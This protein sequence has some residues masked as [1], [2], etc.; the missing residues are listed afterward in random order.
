V[1]DAL[2]ALLPIA[3]AAAVFCGLIWSNAE[4][5]VAGI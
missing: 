2:K 4:F 1:A 5:T 3:I